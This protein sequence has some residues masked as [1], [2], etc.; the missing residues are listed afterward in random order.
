MH[1][2]KDF[3][4]ITAAYA[5]GVMVFFYLVWSLLSLALPEAQL[6]IVRALSTS[7]GINL[8]D[9]LM[10][11]TSMGLRAVGVV[12]IISFLSIGLIVLNVFFSAIITA[13]IIQPKIPLLTSSRGV[14]ST[15]WNG[16]RHFVLVRMSNFHKC[17]LV[18]VNLNV[19]LTVE[20][21]RE[22]GEQFM[23][24]LP[25]HEFTPPRVLFMSKKMPWS[26]A[27][28][29]DA[30]LSNSL[31]S[32]YHFKPGEPITASFAANKKIIK[33]RRC[34]QI[35]IQ[36]MD[37]DS[38]AKFVIQRKIMVDEQNGENYTLHLH[39]GNFKSLPLQIDDPA[40]LEK[41]AE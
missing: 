1:V 25:V 15:T 36:G 12:A 39:R 29:A 23:C 5:I 26:I 28:P 13:R 7:F 4:K 9:D 40:D 32:D 22:G 14:L 34:L 6:D 21:E 16:G 20:E 19:V 10:V 38:N 31:A 41:F 18:D 37:A 3:V 17:D 11:R 35:L 8:P 24:Y 27:V 2:N 33:V 30:H